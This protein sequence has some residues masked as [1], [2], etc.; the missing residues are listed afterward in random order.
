MRG[1]IAFAV[2]A[3][4]VAGV[5]FMGR[6]DAR[7]NDPTHPRPIE[8]ETYLEP[9]PTHAAKGPV[10]PV[11]IIL[12]CEEPTTLEDKTPDGKTAVIK[13]GQQSEG[14]LVRFLEMPDEWIKVCGFDK[15][16]GTAGSLPGKASY[17]FE[18][19]RDDTYYINLR[20]KWL[21]NCGNSVWVKVD[22]G[23]YFNLEDENGK[24]EEK[25][26][27]WAWHQLFVAGKLK[28]FELKQGQ[29]TL[30][31]NTREDGPRLDQWVISTEATPPVGGPAKKRKD[32]SP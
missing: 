25:N 20:A 6:S 18:A 26:F 10:F 14:A 3:V 23:E 29:H 12:E 8:T 32:P 5:I 30:W 11:K 1:V 31:L 22:D 19:P 15:V 7:P 13:V 9:V 2:I 21:D 27:S 28:G 17:T 16:K 24:I 4:L